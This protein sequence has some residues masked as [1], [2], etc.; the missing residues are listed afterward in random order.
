MLPGP[1]A[2]A[3]TVDAGKIHA[4]PEDIRAEES[5]ALADD[6][7]STKRFDRF[8]RGRSALW[9]GHGATR[10]GG[11]QRHGLQIRLLLKRLERP[12]KI[13]GVDTLIGAAGDAGDE[14]DAG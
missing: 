14:I 7:M 9:T 5:C 13:A 8:A 11:T 6:D 10:D 1:M 2:P 3:M 12:L 4:S